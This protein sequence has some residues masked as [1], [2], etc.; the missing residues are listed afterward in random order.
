[1]GVIFAELNVKKNAKTNIMKNFF[2]FSSIVAMLLLVACNNDPETIIVTETVT[3]TDT[4][5]VVEQTCVGTACIEVLVTENI[6]ADETW[7][8]DSVYIL[9]G[10]IAV[11]SGATLTIEAGTVIKGQ[12]GTGANATALLVARGAKLNAAGTADAPIIFTTVA[13]EIQ[14]GEIL[15]PNLDESISGLWGGVIILGN[16]PASLKN[17]VAET[18]IEGIP[19]SDTNGLY[20]GTA[21][22]DNS[23]TINYISIRHGGANIGEGNEINGLSLGGVGSGTVIEG[24]EVVANADDGIEFFG[25]TVNVSKVLIWNS[26]DDGLDTDQDYQ[27]TVTDFMI[28]TPLGGSAFELDGPEGT[29]K[30]NGSTGF[31]TFKNGVVYAGADIVEGVDWDSNTNAAVQDIYIFGIDATWAA[32]GKGVASFQGDGSGTSSG[33]EVTMPTGVAVATCFTSAAGIITE[34]TLAARTK[35]PQKSVFADWTWAGKS[36][37]LTDLGL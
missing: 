31:H 36:G 33:W 27:G 35:G 6:S 7:S 5:T 8:S 3:E 30:V 25:G 34:T 22:A 14:P 11:E 2:I 16:A 20:G 13:D 24:V 29:A 12:A 9:G 15:S 23:G 21:A 28:V 10:R 32:T 19:T 26:N 4:V 1:M 17:D 18:N 37:A